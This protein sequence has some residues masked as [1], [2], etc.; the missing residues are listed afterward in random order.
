MTA[1]RGACVLRDLG[2]AVGQAHAALDGPCGHGLIAKRR[3][4]GAGW[5]GHYAIFD[6]RRQL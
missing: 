1:W 6:I 5:P 3:G 2:I 4:S